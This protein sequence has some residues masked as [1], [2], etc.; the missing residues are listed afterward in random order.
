MLLAIE[1]AKVFGLKI[2]TFFRYSRKEV[3]IFGELKI[4]FDEL[5][6]KYIHQHSAGKYKIDIYLPDYKLAIEIDENNHSGRNKTKEKE[7]ETF[8]KNKLG[9]QFL[10]CNP[11]S[12]T[13][14]IHKLTAQIIK[15]I[16]Q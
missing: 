14:S 15:F 7:R 9:C 13:F 10:R 2:K 16:Y 4:F 8:I 11:D 1:I 12:K 5:N 6:I 3:E